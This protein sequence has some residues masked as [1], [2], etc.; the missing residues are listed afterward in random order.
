[1]IVLQQFFGKIFAGAVISLVILGTGCPLYGHAAKSQENPETARTDFSGVA[2]FGY[3]SASLDSVLQKSPGET[4]RTLGLMPLA[5]LPVSINESAQL[6]ARSAVDV[7]YLVV[8]VTGNLTRAEELSRHSRFDELTRLAD[9][10]STLMAEGDYYLDTM[11]RAAVSI[12]LTLNVDSAPENSALKQTYNEVLSKIEKIRAMLNFQKELFDSIFNNLALSEDWKLLKPTGVTLKLNTPAAYV[13]DSI[14]FEGRLVSGNNSLAGREIDIL[15]DGSLNLSMTTGRE[16]DFGGTLTLPYL[17]EP[18]MNLQALYYPRDK[19]IGLYLGS[20]S[21]EV[22]VKALYYR[23]AL[24]F[25]A[26]DKAYPGLDTTIIADLDFGP[27]TP[28]IDRKAEIYLD[29]VFV[30]EVPV[31]DTLTAEILV[32]PE[33]LVGR[34]VVTV[35]CQAEGRYAPVI[36]STGLNVVKAAPFVEADFPSFILIPGNFRLTGKLYSEVGPVGGAPVSIILRQSKTEV[37]SLTDGSFNTDIRVGLGPDFIGSQGMTIKVTPHEPWH[38]AVQ[39]DKKVMMVNLVTCAGFLLLVVFLGIF[40]PARLRNQ[41]ALNTRVKEAPVKPVAVY[42]APVYNQRASV[43]SEVAGD[44]REPRNI[45]LHWYRLTLELVAKVTHN[46]IKPDQT[47]REYARES[48]RKIGLAG[49]PFLK[50]TQTAEKLLYSKFE[51]SQK[52]A[53][54]SRELSRDIEQGLKK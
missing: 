46:L 47:L 25:K 45:I 11:S 18:E 37:V 4:G 27:S 26:A 2:L 12:G 52:D 44:S 50:M 29:D 53:E 9:N 32:P 30:S 8:D 35:S 33:T 19:D 38:S 31:R 22:K 20:L 40:L 36:E 49:V 14:K 10:M 15:L 23:V 24:A 17:Y 39:I 16:G 43:L 3:Y 7:A 21:P 13:G 1:M 28:L 6:F 54:E 51:P 48:S 34:H 41:F 42:P 5:N